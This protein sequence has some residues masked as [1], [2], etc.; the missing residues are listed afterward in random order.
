MP[1]SRVLLPWTELGGKSLYAS[2]LYIE[3]LLALLNT[4]YESRAWIFQERLLL[5]RILYMMEY[6]MYFH[7]EVHARSELHPQNRHVSSSV[8][9]LTFLLKDG[10]LREETSHWGTEGTLTALSPWADYFKVT[11]ICSAKR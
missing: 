8:N 5:P 4:K 6:Q 7:C 2:P 9:P 3:L 1:G 11:R 10:P